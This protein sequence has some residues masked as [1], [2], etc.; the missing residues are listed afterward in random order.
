MVFHKTE[1]YKVAAV[2]K[3]LGSSLPECAASFCHFLGRYV[4]V[5]F[6]SQEKVRTQK[7]DYRKR[8]LIFYQTLFGSDF[9]LDS[10]MASYTLSYSWP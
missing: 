6:S 4:I 2:C 5:T 7:L 8:Q 3:I 9:T 1:S 10:S